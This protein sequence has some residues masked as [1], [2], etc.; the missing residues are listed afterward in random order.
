[1]DDK[2]INIDFNDIP[3]GSNA[4]VYANFKEKLE[5]VQSFP[6]TYTFKFIITGD[7]T[8][9][10]ELR[11]VLP[12][13]EFVEKPSKTGKYIAITVN[14]QVQNADEVVD[15]YKQASAIKGIMLL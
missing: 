12:N 1:M 6:G 11:A 10:E 9:I 8:K 5:N 15:I 4:D 13:D 2:K 14:K 7:H 3:E